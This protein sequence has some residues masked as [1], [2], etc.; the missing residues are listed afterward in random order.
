[1]SKL[2]LL[3]ILFLFIGIHFITSFT[4]SSLYFTRVLSYSLFDFQMPIMPWWVFNSKWVV[5][6]AIESS[7]SFLFIISSILI[8][9]SVIY[10]KKNKLII[11]LTLSIQYTIYM[12]SNTLLYGFSIEPYFGIF[13]HSTLVLLIFIAYHSLSHKLGLTK[14]WTGCV[15][16]AMLNLL[17]IC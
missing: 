5:S 2:T 1:M 6:F 11:L 8:T 10:L 16:I 14:P 12:R 17:L 3:R 4:T 13:I 15:T 9:F 7:T